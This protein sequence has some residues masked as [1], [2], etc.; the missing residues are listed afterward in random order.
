L[1]NKKSIKK[2]EG[3]AATVSGRHSLKPKQE[4]WKKKQFILGIIAAIAIVILVIIAITNPFFS[5]PA[6]ITADKYYKISDHDLLSNGSTGIYFISW[7]GC[8]IGATDSWALYYV[9]NSTTNIYSHVEEHEAYNQDIYANA[10]E[11][12]G[13]PGLLFNGSF[14][15]Q[16]H[17]KMAT[18]YPL[19]MYN[20]TM[21]GTVNNAPIHGTLESYGLS[22]INS[23]YPAGVAKMFN[24]YASDITYKGH[25]ETTF[26]ITGPH[27]A[28]I[29]NSFMYNPTGT[30]GSGTW[31]DN[32]ST[33]TYQPY[34]PA[35]VMSEMGSDSAIISAANNFEKNLI[36][37]E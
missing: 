18:F 29:L 3:R 24:K 13:Q 4:F 11:T 33:N 22:L 10:A 17:G 26:I 21:T 23:T 9:M 31:T 25:L 20:Q 1:A 28:Y 36:A 16:Y 14:S 5:P 6:T 2:G 7:Y 34:P 32:P 37:V 8:P 30:L 27:G 35:T 15:F 19:Y 12:E